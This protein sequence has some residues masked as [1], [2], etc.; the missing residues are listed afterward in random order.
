[1]ANTASSFIPEAVGTV[2]GDFNNDGKLDF[3]TSGGTG[4]VYVGLGTGDGTFQTK[5]L[6]NTYCSFNSSN[7]I[8]TG[9]FNADGNE[10]VAACSVFLGNG[11]GT[12]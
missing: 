2:I 4:Q 5:Q 8:V 11:D 12:V 6:S 3:L 10:D 1:M 9:D 7:L